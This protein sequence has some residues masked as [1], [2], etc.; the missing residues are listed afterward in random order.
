MPLHPRTPVLIGQG[1]AVDRDTN[2]STAKHPVALM[3]DAVAEAFRDASIGVPKQVDSVRVV[4]L[5]SWKYANAAYAL[6]DGCGISAQEYA[7]TPHGGN[8]P[9]TLVN[10]SARQIADGDLDL[11]V[12]AGGECA[13]TRSVVKDP[14]ALPWPDPNAAGDSVPPATHVVEDLA[15]LND[16][17]QRLGIVLPVQYYP[18]FESA[19]RA[20]A[21]RSIADHDRRIAELW[22][23]FSAVAAQNPFAWSRSDLSA[24]DILAVNADNRMIGLPYRKVMNSN[25]QVNLAAALVMCSAQKAESLGV[26]RDRWVFPWSGTDC[27]EHQFVSNRWSFAETPAVRLGGARALQ[28]AGLGN[29][30]V[31]LVDLYSCFPSAVQLGAA[32]L[33]LDLASRLTLTGGLSFAGGPW[34]NYVMHA[35]ATVMMRLREQPDEHA[36]IWA[37]GGYATKHAFGT[38]ATTPPQGGFKH[39]SLQSEI[40]ALPRRE[41]AV[42]DDARGAAT[43]EAYTVM[44][45]RAGAPERLIAAALLADGRRA[46]VNAADANVARDFVSGEQVGRRIVLRRSG[47]LQ[48][49]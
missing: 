34:N 48:S 36:L 19:I 11:V 29:D 12:L 28:L 4:R 25:N 2:P 17:E 35:I 49:A 32:S 31:S 40:D 42:G 16:E 30:D 27:H 46:W 15:L 43:I 21:G 22:S 20:A 24:D 26:P 45:D 8:M 41:L 3:V 33:G 39:E 9:Q 7:T 14:G 18:M 47:E 5:L 44:H 38:Y 37:N 10:L 6:A 1:Q 13:R 23:R